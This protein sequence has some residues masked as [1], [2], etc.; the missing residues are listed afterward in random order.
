MAKSDPKDLQSLLQGIAD[1]EK[2]AVISFI[3]PEKAIRK[4]PVSFDYVSITIDDLYTI[5]T[6]IEEI[7]SKGALPDKLILVIHTPGGLAFAAT[8]IAKYLQSTFP[9]GIEAYVPYEASSGGTVL[10]LAAKAIVLD[11]VANLT[12]IDPQV[13]YNGTR[14]SSVSYQQAIRDFEERWGK[15][16]PSE[17]P[18]PHQQMAQSFDPIVDK[19]MRKLVLDSIWVA[20]ELMNKAQNPKNDPK[21]RSDIISTAFGLVHTNNPHSH[22]IDKN[23]AISDFNLPVSNDAAKQANLKVF[24][25]WV[26]HKLTDTEQTTHIIEHYLPA[27]VVPSPTPTTPV[28]KKK[29]V[30]KAKKKKA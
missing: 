15:L 29:A 25:K 9:K 30:T 6:C 12:P 19:E 28:S 4:S 1:T 27:V 24:K 10:C 11:D 26:R 13:P 18:S 3:A 14:I 23:E 22:V 8:K 21:K 20:F 5:E 2:A 7:A 17:I 16:R